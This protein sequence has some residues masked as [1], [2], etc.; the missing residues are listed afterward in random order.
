[1]LYKTGTFY[2]HLGLYDKAIL[3]YE[4]VL[5]ID[6]NHHQSFHDL[7]R[8]FLKKSDYINTI[9]NFKKAIKL[10][11]ENY[12][13]IYSLYNLLITVHP[14]RYMPGWAEGYEILL[15]GSQYLGHDKIIFLSF[16]AFKHL[17]KNNLIFALLE[18][19]KIEEKDLPILEDIFQNKTLIYCLKYGLVC[20]YDFEKLISKIR[21]FYLNYD[22]KFLVT[23]NTH[24]FLS[25]LAQYNFFNNYIFSETDNE[26][27]KLDYLEKKL[28]KDLKI[29]LS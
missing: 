22:Q 6:L 23:Y 10:E 16:N 15:K 14:D 27:K 29:K 1:M 25:S 24:N 3:F 8:S 7:G 13:Y 4:K 11:S 2:F 17:K 12:E 18:K 19:E 21:E 5:S 26:L 20:D 9:K 28:T